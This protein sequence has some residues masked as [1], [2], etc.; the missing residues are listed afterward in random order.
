[1]T[2]DDP[3]R[4]L[5]LEEFRLHAAD[6]DG[7]AARIVA[8]T[9]RGIEP[10]IPLLTSIDDSR[11]VATLR[12]LHAGEP[13]GTDPVQHAALDAFVATWEA[14]KHYGPRIAERSQSPSSSFRLAVTESGINPSGEP[15][16]APGPGAPSD[17]STS[18]PVGLV[19]IGTPVGTHAGL[20]VLLGSYDA[21]RAAD[22]DPSRWPLPLSRSLGV[23]IYQSAA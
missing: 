3:I 16:D 6:V 22:R 5:V 20:L 15:P 8:A 21:P 11:D 1:M 7:S 10:P 9:A 19:W 4:L 18:R 17:G 14:P 2:I 23:R 13:T 12:A